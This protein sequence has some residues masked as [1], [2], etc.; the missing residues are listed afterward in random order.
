VPRCEI[1]NRKLDVMNVRFCGG[2]VC[3]ASVEDYIPRCIICGGLLMAGKTCPVS[4]TWCKGGPG[5][6]PVSQ[7]V[8][9]RKVQVFKDKESEK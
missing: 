9:E 7:A 3:K 1:C 6:D 4:K 2:D 8:I 5:E